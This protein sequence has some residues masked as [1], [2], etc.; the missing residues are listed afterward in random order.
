MITTIDKNTALV[1]ID[2]QKMIVQLPG[3]HPMDKLIENSAKLLA[4]FRKANLP[5]VIVNV[6]PT[7]S[8]AFN[9]RKDNAPRSMGTPPADWLDITPEIKVEAG[10]ILIT[11]KTWGAFYQT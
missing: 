1:L 10:D 8:P 2:L 5:V 6:N 4:A 7:N 9:T 3:V 11:K